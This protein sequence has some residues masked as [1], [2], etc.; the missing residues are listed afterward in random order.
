[1]ENSNRN[2]YLNLPSDVV[3]AFHKNLKTLEVNCSQILDR[4]SLRKIEDIATKS[5]SKLIDKNIL[6]LDFFNKKVIFK[7][8]EK[9]LFF[10]NNDHPQG[11]KTKEGKKLDKKLDLFSSFLILHYLDKSDGYPLGDE[12]ISYRELPG[13]LFY[14]ET[15]PDVLKPLVERY[16]SDSKSFIEDTVSIGGRI[17]GDFE[18]GVVIF[19]FSMFPVLMILYE[20]DEE[21]DADLKVFFDSSAP[22]YLKTDVIKLLL[23]Y[24]VNIY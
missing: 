16:G 3:K 14:W 11:G 18:N 2:T 13:G 9:R 10:L 21:F 1:M 8:K 7:S 23:I 17:S 22:H 20:K 19:P 4:L 6:Q 24:L 12:W 5:G 15:I